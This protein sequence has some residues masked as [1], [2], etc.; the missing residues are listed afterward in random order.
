MHTSTK[1][2]FELNTSTKCNLDKCSNT[3]TAGHAGNGI[4]KKKDGIRRKIRR[5]LVLNAY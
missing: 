2:K 1:C 4:R 5:L 3:A